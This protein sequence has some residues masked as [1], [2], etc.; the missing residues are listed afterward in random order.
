MADE[1]PQTSGPKI[2]KWVVALI[3]FGLV[4]FM[5]ISVSYKIRHFGP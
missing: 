2:P 3:L 4:V 1:T 5:Y